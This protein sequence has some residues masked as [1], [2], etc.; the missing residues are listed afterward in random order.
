MQIVIDHTLGRSSRYV[1]LVPEYTTD[2][3]AAASSFDVSIQRIADL[4]LDDIAKG[5][6]R[7]YR[8]ILP[9]YDPQAKTRIKEVQLLRSNT[10]LTGPPT[11]WSGMTKDVNEGRGRTHLYLMWK[12]G[13]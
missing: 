2:L 3:T 8:Y 4:A 9:K 5:A 6:H 12:A 13:V 7:G 1:W 10:T 11:G